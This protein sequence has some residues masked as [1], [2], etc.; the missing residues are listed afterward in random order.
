[1]KIGITSLAII[2]VFWA[3]FFMF[4]FEGI[5]LSNRYFVIFAGWDLPSVLI[6]IH[7]I[8]LFVLARFSM[9]EK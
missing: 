1:M 5:F 9:E 6:V 7:L 3:V 4:F 2:L 8:L